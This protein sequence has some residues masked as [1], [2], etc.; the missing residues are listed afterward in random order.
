MRKITVKDSEG[1]VIE[2]N[3][4][5][6]FTCDDT[7]KTYVAIDYQKEIFEKNS[8]YN[9]LDIL[10]VLKEAKDGLVLT[11]ISDEEWPLV[12]KALQYKIFANIKDAKKDVFSNN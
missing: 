1:N 8:S 3:F 9:N 2:A 11:D 10:E 6:A 12:K 5:L 4:I 7:H